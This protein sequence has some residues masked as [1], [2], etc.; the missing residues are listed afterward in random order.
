MATES[1]FL[2]VHSLSLS[3]FKV[4]LFWLVRSRFADRA[5]FAVGVDGFEYV[6]ARFL[7]TEGIL[8]Q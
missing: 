7:S 1:G 4:L 6:R 2:S 5:R 3:A 8:E